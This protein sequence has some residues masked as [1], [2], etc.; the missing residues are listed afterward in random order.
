MSFSGN[1][2]QFIPL[3]EELRRTLEK[4]GKEAIKKQIMN[5]SQLLEEAFVKFSNGK[6]YFGGDD[7]RYVD[8]VLGSFIGWTKLI[9]EI[10]DFKVFDEVRTPGLGLAGWAKCMS[11]HEAIK[12]VI[13]QNEILMKLYTLLQIYRPPRVVST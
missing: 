5:G 1:H 10:N 6:P 4:E 13:P 8:S 7:I 9:E 2:R 11:S 12:T 3:Y